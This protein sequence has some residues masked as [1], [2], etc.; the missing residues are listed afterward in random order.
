[1]DNSVFNLTMR[2]LLAEFHNRFPCFGDRGLSG[3][4]GVETEICVMLKL[5]HICQALLGRGAEGGRGVCG[6]G[7]MVCSLHHG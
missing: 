7:Y 2:S 6:Y 3:G 4:L 5:Q 1:M